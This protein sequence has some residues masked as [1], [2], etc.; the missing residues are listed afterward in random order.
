MTTTVPILRRDH[1]NFAAL[2]NVLER[3]VN[4]VSS[5]GQPDFDILNGAVGYFRGYP[6][7]YHHPKEDIIYRLLKQRGPNAVSGIASLLQDHESIEEYLSRFGQAVANIQNG[8]DV[9]REA[10]KRVAQQFLSAQREHIALEENTFFPYAIQSLNADDWASLGTD[11]SADQAHFLASVR[12]RPSI[13]FANTFWNG[14]PKTGLRKRWA[15]AALNTMHEALD[16]RSTTVVPPAQICTVEYRIWR[17]QAPK[18]WLRT[19]GGPPLHA[20]SLLRQE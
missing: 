18:R 1:I 16:T 7:Q 19:S 2:L 3:Q 14:R 10:F 17:R 5:D 4:V 20:R 13:V 15:R 9:S 8:E 6:A 11:K 12:P